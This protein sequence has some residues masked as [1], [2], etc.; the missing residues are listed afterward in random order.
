MTHF[1]QEAHL[2]ILL[3]LSN[4]HA[5]DYSI[6]EPVG[7][8]LI[9]TTTVGLFMGLLAELQLKGIEKCPKWLLKSSARPTYNASSKSPGPTLLGTAFISH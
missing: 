1:L 2:L 6:H 7:P 4:M 9:Q 8:I 5:S 3:I